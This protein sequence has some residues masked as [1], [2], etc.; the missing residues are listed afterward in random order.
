M[1]TISVR[2]HFAA[3]HR[4]LGLVGAGAKCRNPHGHTFFVTF[5]FRQSTDWPPPVEFGAAKASLRE[6]IKDRYD[7]GFFVDRSDEAMLKFLE[8]EKCRHHVFDGPPTTERIAELLARD[9]RLL[10]N[11]ATLVSVAVEEGPENTATYEAT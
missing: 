1:S 4:I 10:V 11:A 6:R 3:G 9:A 2:L 7:H 5:V 8:Q